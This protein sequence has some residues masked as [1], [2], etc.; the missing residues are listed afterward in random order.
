MLLLWSLCAA[1]FY[2]PPFVHTLYIFGST[3]AK[4]VTAASKAYLTSRERSSFGVILKTK[5]TIL[6]LS[7]DL[8]HRTACLSRSNGSI[9]DCSP[10]PLLTTMAWMYGASTKS[11]RWQSGCCSQ[12]QS[13]VQAEQRHSEIRSNH[14]S[15]H[16]CF[17]EALSGELQYFVKVSIR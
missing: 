13:E 4:Q 16:P 14:Q 1:D 2:Q 15:G 8:W 6:C 9:S 5:Y 11:N 3:H 17:P 7:A 12:D 10:E